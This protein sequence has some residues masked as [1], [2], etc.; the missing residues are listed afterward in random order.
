LDETT[1]AAKAA[2]LLGQ[3]SSGYL[4]DSDIML[5]NVEEMLEGLEWGQS[6]RGGGADQIEK[7]LL[8]ELHAL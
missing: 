5:T 3:Q 7:R 6:N 8:G 4:D 1:A 2:A